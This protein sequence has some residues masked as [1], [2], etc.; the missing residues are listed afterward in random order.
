M[1]IAQYKGL[2]N[3]QLSVV[4]IEGKYTVYIFILFTNI[5]EHNGIK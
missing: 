3:R 5:G 4:I 2:I 1:M